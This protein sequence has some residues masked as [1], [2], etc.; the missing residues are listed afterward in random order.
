MSNIA[1]RQDFAD[2]QT[3]HGSDLNGVNGVVQSFINGG[4]LGDG[5]ITTN[6]A[7]KIAQ[8]KLALNADPGAHHARHEPGGADKVVNID[9]L[10]TGT[11]L[12]VH[13]SRHVEGGADPLPA[14]SQ[15]ANIIKTATLAALVVAPRTGQ[16]SFIQNALGFAEDARYPRIYAL[17]NSTANLAGRGVV[18]GGALYACAQGPSPDAIAKIVIDTAT[19]TL[20]SLAASDVARGLVLVGT[21]IYILCGNGSSNIKIKKLDSNDVLTTLVDLNASGATLTTAYFMRPNGVGTKLYGIGSDGATAYFWSVNIDGTGLQKVNTGSANSF[22]GLAYGKRGSEEKL[23]SIE[24]TAANNTLV[25]RN[26]DLTADATFN[27]GLG[28]NCRRLVYDGEHI[29][30]G[31]SGGAVS[32]WVFDPWGTMRLVMQITNPSTIDGGGQVQDL[33]TDALADVDIFDGRVIHFAGRCTG[34]TGGAGEIRIHPQ[35][36]YL[37]VSRQVS[38]NVTRSPGFIAADGTYCYHGFSNAG[39]SMTL[40][41][42]LR[43]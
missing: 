3:L 29:V 40:R 35:N 13:A 12:S 38:D 43:D 7:E 2:G 16:E 24:G 23:W 39:A 19:E 14:A 42:I 36:G 26:I 30:I 15:N 27:A 41:R 11:L 32:H 9:I 34:G 33:A 20:I 31:V 6:P 5:N 10:G 22:Y 17:S 37:A 28:V 4:N 21:N 1:I 8:S 18:R 25:R